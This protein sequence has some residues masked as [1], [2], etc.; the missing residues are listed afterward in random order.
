MYK[1]PYSFYKNIK[2]PESEIQHVIKK[3]NGMSNQMLERDECWAQRLSFLKEQ[4]RP[5]KICP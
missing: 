5:E 3:L 1:P 4:E 2:F